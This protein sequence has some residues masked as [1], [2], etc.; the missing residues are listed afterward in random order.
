[1]VPPE[2]TVPD[3]C[4]GVLAVH[5]AADGGLARV[6]LPGGVLSASQLR[7]LAAAAVELGDGHL[8][9]T[10]RANVQIRALQ[11]GAPVELS[12]RLYAAGLL[13][14]ITHERVRNILASPLSGLDQYSLYDVLPLAGELD[15]L[16][17]ATPGLAALP[18][19]FLFALDD[20]RG[21]LESSK[22]DV[23]VRLVDRGRG[24]LLLAG[25]ATGVQ[26]AVE[27]VA[28]V[29]VAAA[30]AFLAV[31]GEQGS[32]AWR[33][34]EL[35][36]GPLLVLKRLGLDGSPAAVPVGVRR[37]PAAAG[38]FEGGVV[39]TVPLGVLGA[40][41]AEALA[42]SGDEVRVTP[43]RSVVVVGNGPVQRLTAVGLVLEKASP[44]NGVTS[45]AG[46]PGCGKALGDVRGDARR[47][48]PGWSGG[49]RVHWSGCERRCGKPGGEFLDVVALGGG[50][51]AVD[52][53]AMG[54][55]EV[56]A[57]R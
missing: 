48:V 17:C 47:V 5:E 11:P 14:S 30:E 19:R 49:G 42:E 8:E 18:G 54:V 36:D 51:Y 7:V 55:D 12:E 20:G 1:M 39:A 6:R 33:L 52:G 57:H 38:V 24:E 35:D 9:L 29:M 53:V 26:V 28:E 22:P 16:L 31:R 40:E 3:R 2:R 41:Q 21:D 4:P 44:W 34:G 32:E 56:R 43:W 10:S 13:P 25:V 23:A 50:G 27:R 45:C 15:R 46:R 37:G